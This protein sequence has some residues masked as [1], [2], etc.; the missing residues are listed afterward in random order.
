MS[1][2]F[3]SNARTSMPL[4]LDGYEAQR[5]V[6]HVFNPVIGGGNVIAVPFAAGPRTGTLT[7]VYLEMWRAL[8]FDS[9]LRGTYPVRLDDSDT[10]D[11][12]MT[13]LASGTIRVYPGEVIVTD[14]GEEVV[15]WFVEFG[16]QEVI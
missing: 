6:R 12:G 3:T 9:L 1:T 10:P 14:D 8:E 4:V 7:A 15:P 16:Y 11:I 2:T 13:F 5:E